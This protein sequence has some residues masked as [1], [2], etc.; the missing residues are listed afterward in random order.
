MARPE[1]QDP[2]RWEREVVAAVWHHLKTDVSVLPAPLV[3]NVELEGG[4]P[5]TKLVI[6]EHRTDGRSGEQVRSQYP[7]WTGTFRGPD[8]L[9]RTPAWA[10]ADICMWLA[11]G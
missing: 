2:A 5:D 3:Q 7:L 11:G 8:G 10:A 4:Y 6:T 9:Q 1:H